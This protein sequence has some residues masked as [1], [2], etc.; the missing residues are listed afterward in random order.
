MYSARAEPTAT[1]STPLAWEEVTSEL[2]PRAYT[3]AS[4]PARV[5]EVGDLWAEGMR[6]ANS[7]DELVANV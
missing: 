7:L 1:V 5:R 6:R 3:I 4:V 2:D